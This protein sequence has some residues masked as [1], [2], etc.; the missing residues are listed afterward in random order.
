MRKMSSG[1]MILPVLYSQPVEKHRYVPAQVQRVL[2][3]LVNFL[4]LD[5]REHICSR[6]LSCAIASEQPRK[7]PPVNPVSESFHF[8]YLSPAFHEL[9]GLALVR[10]YEQQALM[11]LLRALHD[12]VREFHGGPV[13]FPDAIY[14]QPACRILEVVEYV[15]NGLDELHYVLLVERQDERAL[16]L[17]ANLAH[18]VV[19]LKLQPGHLLAA[20]LHPSLVP[21]YVL[22]RARS[23]DKELG[24]PQQAIEYLGLPRKEHL[25]PLTRI[26]VPIFK[27]LQCAFDAMAV[28]QV[29]IVRS[30]LKIGKGKL[31]AHVAH[32]SLDGY[33]RAEVYDE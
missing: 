27:S 3:H 12:E 30:D 18:H 28:K 7:G 15:V 20:L 29:I 10:L 31:S 21:R 22:E 2:E 32:A 17:I 1:S 6:N 13:L 14:I 4:P 9:L 16:H 26:S 8:V 25:S 33:K 5:Y 23:L 24:V 19:A 11:Y